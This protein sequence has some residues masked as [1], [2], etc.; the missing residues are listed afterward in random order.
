MTD[1]QTDEQTLPLVI[2]DCR[3]ASVTE[4]QSMKDKVNGMIL[5]EMDKP[6]F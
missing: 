1:R 3:V 5:D 2:V 6:T 4:K